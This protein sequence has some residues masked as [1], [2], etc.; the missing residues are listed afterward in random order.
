VIPEVDRLVALSPPALADVNAAVRTVGANTVGLG[1]LPSEA[2]AFVD[3]AVTDFAE[4]FSADVSSLT[5]RQ[6]AAF[7]T[8]LG[9]NVFG[10]TA[11]VMIADFVPRVRAG[12]TL[13]VSTGRRNRSTGITRRTRPTTCSTP[14]RRPSG[15]CAAWIR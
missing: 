8:I 3:P 4:Q 9:P 11:L 13:W 14:S 10:A 7:A 1:P 5:G 15:G 12:L 6:R 2:G